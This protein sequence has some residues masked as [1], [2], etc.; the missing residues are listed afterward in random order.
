MTHT[1]RT[2]ARAAA[3]LGSLAG[4]ATLS[5]SGPTT[6]TTSTQAEFLKGQALGVSVDEV[7][8]VISGPEISLLSDAA[9]PQIWSLAGVA[10]DWVAGTGGDGRVIRGRAGQV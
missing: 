6:W 3:L 4:A 9:S 2:Y 7:G 10:D 5:A 1:L 8:R